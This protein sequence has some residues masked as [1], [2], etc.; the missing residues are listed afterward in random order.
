[1]IFRL[2][3]KYTITTQNDLKP[4]QNYFQE[5]LHEEPRQLS[6]PSL[7]MSALYLHRNAQVK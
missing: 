2:S 5:S 3:F 6:Q 7:K 1:M 4:Y